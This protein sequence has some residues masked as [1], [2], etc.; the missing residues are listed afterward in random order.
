MASTTSPGPGVGS[1]QFSSANSQ[2]PRN[3]TPFMVGCEGSEGGNQEACGFTDRELR[4]IPQ[5]ESGEKGRCDREDV[6]LE[7]A[8]SDRGLWVGRTGSGGRVLVLLH[9]MS[10]NGGVWSRSCRSWNPAGRAAC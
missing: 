3:T 5:A 9:G 8:I 2:S 7:G 10:A 6:L 4:P 1:G